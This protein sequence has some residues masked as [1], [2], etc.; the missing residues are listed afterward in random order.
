MCVYS[1]GSRGWGSDGNSG[2]VTVDTDCA[3]PLLVMVVM[4]QQWWGRSG[5]T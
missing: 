3:G 1:G 4:E 5:G 2:G